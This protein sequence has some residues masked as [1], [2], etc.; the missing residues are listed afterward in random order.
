MTLFSDNSVSFQTSSREDSQLLSTIFPPPSAKEVVFL[1]YCMN[2]DRIFIML[3][4]GTMCIY[5]IDSTG[6]AIL[7]KMH[8][9]SM[10]KDRNNKTLNQ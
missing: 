6:T 8:S 4:N 9:S 5:R 2:L 3:V 10:I 7:E 1:S